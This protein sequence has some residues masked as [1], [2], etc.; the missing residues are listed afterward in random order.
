MSKSKYL[1][2]SEFKSRHQLR[3][4]EQTIIDKWIFCGFIPGCYRLP[5]TGEWRVPEDALPPYRTTC[6]PGD[7]YYKSIVTAC[8]KH[9][10]P[11]F[12]LYNISETEFNGYIRQ[13]VE[14]KLIYI[15]EIDGIDYYRATIMAQ[16]AYNNKGVKSFKKFIL[17]ALEAVS[18]GA[19][20]AW[21]E[22]S[23]NG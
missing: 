21:I 22:K 9:N 7:D 10:R 5:D 1:T 17:D 8:C 18:K 14:A 3:E 12:Q 16:E 15:E 11:C 6:K 23:M 19:A 4:K 2:V 13:L 20:S